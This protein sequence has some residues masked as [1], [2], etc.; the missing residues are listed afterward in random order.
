MQ[1][2]HVHK[3]PGTFRV[4][5]RRRGNRNE[6][7]FVGALCPCPV[8]RSHVSLVSLVIVGTT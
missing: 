8:I 6:L 1:R 2:A 7:G 4:A 3:R 5:S